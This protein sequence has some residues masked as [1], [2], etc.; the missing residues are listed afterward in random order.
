[1]TDDARAGLEGRMHRPLDGRVA[2]VTGG[3]VR[4]GRAIVE[5]LADRGARV[6]FTWRSHADDARELAEALA[7]RHGADRVLSTRCDVTSES[8]VDA[9]YEAL[10]A[11]FGRI[12]LL[13]NNAA[14]FERTP[15]AELTLDAWRRHIDVNLTGGFLCAKRAGDRMLRGD[16]GVIVNVACAGGVRPW[17]AYLPYSVSKAGV[18]MMTQVLA[19]AL[20][21]KVRVNAIAPGPVLLPESYDAAEQVRA[22]SQTVLGRLGS[23]DDV[24]RAVLFCWD[25][26]FTTGALIPAEG[27]RLIL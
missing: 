14:I 25:S 9:A 22:A 10:D 21:P 19:R 6:A 18:I 17:P 23:P 11:R 26:D 5:A 24:V 7:A 16:G 15:F 27:G 8:D 2:L 1:M 13:V 3:A 12:D 4:L 20:A